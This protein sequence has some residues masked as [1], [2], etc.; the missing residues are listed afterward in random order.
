MYLFLE[1]EENVDVK[2]PSA[3][4]MSLETFIARDF[5]V[6]EHQLQAMENEENEAN[7]DEQFDTTE[8]I[9]TEDILGMKSGFFGRKSLISLSLSLL[10]TGNISESD[11]SDDEKPSPSSSS[12]PQAGDSKE[13]HKHL[14]QRLKTSHSP[15]TDAAALQLS[16]DEL[17]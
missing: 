4:G 12:H 13:A 2:S 6:A 5:S 14:K 8:K 17:E 7:V 15:S 3:L 10:S 16:E 11:S 9:T 1:N